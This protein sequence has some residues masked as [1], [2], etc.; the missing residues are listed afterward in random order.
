MNF[1]RQS[2]QSFYIAQH[3]VGQNIALAEDATAQKIIVQYNPHAQ[4]LLMDE[5][6]QGQLPANIDILFVDRWHS[7]QQKLVRRGKFWELLSDRQIQMI[8]GLQ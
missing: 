8:V 1:G 6:L 5:F 3:A 2:G 4:V 7:F